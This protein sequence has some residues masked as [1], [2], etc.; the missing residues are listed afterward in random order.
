VKLTLDILRLVARLGHDKGQIILILN[1]ED[2][3]FDVTDEFV[4]IIL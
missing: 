3:L 2:L 1:L 4:K